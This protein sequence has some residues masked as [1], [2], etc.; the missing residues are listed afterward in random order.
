MFVGS[1]R[2]GPTRR[3]AAGAPAAAAQDRRRRVRARLRP[4]PPRGY[5][6]ALRRAHRH[7]PGPSEEVWP[8]RLLPIWQADEEIGCLDLESGAITTYDPSRMQT[9]T[10]ATGAGRL[11]LSIARWLSGWSTRLLRADCSPRTAIPPP[12]V[13]PSHAQTETLPVVSAHLARVPLGA[14]VPKKV[15]RSWAMS[16]IACRASDNAAGN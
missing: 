5:A 6:L 8:G 4:A 11:P 14:M 2:V 1:P 16:S 10:M 15:S 7:A 12:C 3:S 13:G 9:S